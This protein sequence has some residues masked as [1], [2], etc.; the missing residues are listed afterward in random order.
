MSPRAAKSAEPTFEQAT[1][2][3]EEIDELM[4]NPETGLEETIALMEEGTKLIRRS[5]KLLQEAELKI[6]QLE[7]PDAALTEGPKPRS[8]AARNAAST[9]DEFSLL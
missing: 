1:A 8:G 5:R 6:Q 2:R 9:S 3:L 7:N 4:N